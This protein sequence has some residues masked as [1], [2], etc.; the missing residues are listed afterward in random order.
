[1][2]ATQ[3]VD[4]AERWLAGEPL[5]N[6]VDKSLGYV[7]S[8]IVTDLSMMSAAAIVAGYSRGEFSPWTPLELHW[9]LSRRTSRR[10]RVSVLVDEEVAWAMAGRH[11]PLV[12]AP[13]SRSAPPTR[14][15]FDQGR[16]PSRRA[17]PTVRGSDL[18]DAHRRVARGCRQA[19]PAARSQHR[20]PR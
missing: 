9:T 11:P 13:G 12:I 1:M 17:R 15:R 8:R 3:F 7:M 14:C 10:Q 2:L 6:V 18:I 5:L 20:V 19:T 4:N 16:V